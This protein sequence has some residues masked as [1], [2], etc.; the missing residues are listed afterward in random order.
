MA[1]DEDSRARR[2]RDR[3][4]PWR[5]R[6]RVETVV[7]AP[8]VAASAAVLVVTGMLTQRGE[9][10]AQEADAPPR[11]LGI[12]GALP[13]RL[14]PRP[15]GSGGSQNSAAEAADPA[16]PDGAA[17]AGRLDIPESVLETYRASAR[18]V[19]D[20]QP[21]CGL[22][23]SVLAALGRV[24]SGHAEGGA[25]DANGTTT[26][27]ILGPVLDGDGVAEIPDTDGGRLDGDPRW[28]RAVGPMQFIPGTWRV[29]AEPGTDPNNLGDATTAAG[30]YLCA[31]GRDLSRPQELARAVFAYNRSGE[32]VREVLVWANAY[33]RG[34]APSPGEL[35]P[36]Q[37]SAPDVTGPYFPRIEPLP[38]ADPVP[39]PRFTPR[40]GSAQPGGSAAPQGP[41]PE[42]SEGTASAPAQPP[43]GEQSPEGSPRPEAPAR[44]SEATSSQPP[45]AGSPEEQAPR[46]TQTPQETQTTPEDQTSPADQTSQE[47]Q[48]PAAEAPAPGDVEVPLP[49]AHPVGES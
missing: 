28:D 33:E 12:A 17:R 27:P 16:S 41:P 48:P 49:P 19:S 25:I 21:G 9:D 4:N 47:V 8:I 11:T 44:P 3:H 1:L 22:H 45:E 46:E 18:A 31:G 42:L 43:A 7:A 2:G 29:V 32:Y 6:R 39:P 5:R 36:P 20:E 34:V 24:E 14:D 38:P 23:W 10:S 13:E 40:A 37:E 26:T 15:P 35:A 30:E